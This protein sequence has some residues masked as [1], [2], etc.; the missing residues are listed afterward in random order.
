VRRVSGFDTDRDWL[1]GAPFFVD[2][3]SMRRHGALVCVNGRSRRM[4]EVTR[5]SS[6]GSTCA[7]L[8]RKR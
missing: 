5:P 8:V 6:D 4:T 2:E 1:M 3:A 7:R